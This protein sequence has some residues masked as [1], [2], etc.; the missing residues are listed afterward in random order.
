ME[1]TGIKS[2]ILKEHDDIYRFI[3]EWVNQLNNGA[4]VVITSKIISLSEGRTAGLLE[5]EKILKQESKKVIETPWAYLT[6]T[7]DGWCINAGVDESNASGKIILLPKDPFGV[8]RNI[9]SYLLKKFSLKKL[10]VIITDTKSVPLRKGTIGRAL[11]YA[12]FQPLKS[13]IGKKD[14]FGRK[15]RVTESNV[16]DAL[17]AA[18]VLVMGEGDEQIPIAVIKNAPVKFSTKKFR[19]LS[20]APEK[21]IYSWV[22]KKYELESQKLPRKNRR[23]K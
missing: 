1:I 23:K 8:A 13:Y 3:D 20:L 19:S 16:T 9:R 5:K 12:G 18:A 15:S 14:L 4:V 22:F 21:D 17:A 11:G 2:R 6:L 10:G 7:K